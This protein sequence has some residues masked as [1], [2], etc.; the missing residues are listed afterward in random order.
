M[1]LPTQGVI[2]PTS[3]LCSATLPNLVLGPSCSQNRENGTPGLPSWPPNITGGQTVF[4]LS[5]PVFRVSC[6]AGLRASQA[7]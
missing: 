6:V 1:A 7:F 2:P 5:P 4:G 3:N